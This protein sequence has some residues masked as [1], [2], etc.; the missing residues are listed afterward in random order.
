[1]GFNI[2]GN[3]IPDSIKK[4]DMYTNTKYSSL[5]LKNR[6]PAIKEII[7]P[8]MKAKFLISFFLVFI[9]LNSNMMS[10]NIFSSNHYK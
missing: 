5:L 3:K 10:F 9:F 2:K 1:M 4:P 7:R 8:I 6:N